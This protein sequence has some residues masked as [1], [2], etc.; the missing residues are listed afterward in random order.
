MN[1]WVNHS[2]LEFEN[3]PRDWCATSLG[4]LNL[5]TNFVGDSNVVEGFVT[6]R[7]NLGRSYIGQIKID[8]GDLN[9]SYISENSLVELGE[10]GS[11]DENGMSYPAYIE[12][13]GD[14]YLYYTGWIE[15]K[16]VKWYNGIG[17]LKKVNSGWQ[18]VSKA[19]VIHRTD[20]DYIGF[21]SN[22][23]LKL[24]SSILM[25]VTR[26][27]KWNTEDSPSYNLKFGTS[28]DLLS[29]EFQAQPILEFQES[30]YIHSKPLLIKYRNKYLLFFSFRGQNYQIGCA[31]SENLTNWKRVDDSLGLRSC[32]V[33]FFNEMVCY[34]SIAISNSHAYLFYTGDGYG[35][36]GMG[37]AKVSIEIF[38]ELVDM[39]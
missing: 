23:L 34:P 6:G 25:V 11:F 35:R 26:F 19:P 18:R 17:L 5:K 8:L 4:G 22:A 14:E 2:K 20:I 30:E 3:L 27:E 9:N 24:D 21:G 15:G 16:H 31:V 38:N 12:Y 36:A 1:I 32:Q 29:F 7:D 37:M 13:E 28:N 10:K 33:A 39:L